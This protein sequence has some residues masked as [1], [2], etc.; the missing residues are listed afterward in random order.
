MSLG[1]M[2]GKYSSFVLC[3]F[4]SI[5]LVFS[6]PAAF[7][8]A[9]N[10]PD[11]TSSEPAEVFDTN[12]SHFPEMECTTFSVY[13]VES[14][15]FLV[16]KNIN[17]PLPPASITKVMTVLMAL[18][19]MELQDTITI[20]RAMYEGIPED[21]SKLFVVEG[22]IFT[23]ED[24]LYASLLI[25]AN[26]AAR[27]LA[28]TMA[29]SEEAFAEMMNK[30]ALELGCT[31]TNFTNS[32]GFADPEHLTTAHDMI[33]I[34]NEA[35]KNDV[36]RKISTATGYIIQPTN[37]Q[38]EQRAL[39]NSNRYISVEEL[40]YE[41]YIG[42]KTGFTDISGYTLVAGAEKDG[43]RLVGALFGSTASPRRYE[44]LR[45]AFEYCFAN[46]ELLKLDASQFEEIQGRVHSAVQDS[47]VT[48]GYP[49]AIAE[50]YLLFDDYCSLR[51]GGAENYTITADT[52]AITIRN[53]SNR[54]DLE[55][56]VYYSYSDGVRMKAGTIC[57][58][59]AE[60]HSLGKP[61]E[62][63]NF[64]F[65]KPSSEGVFTNILLIFIL[66]LIVFALICVLIRTI[67]R[68]RRN[69]RRKYPRI[70]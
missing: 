20:T 49:L 32:F 5:F 60:I 7:L 70:L 9:D 13:D 45:N 22:E 28:L 2:S 58:T 15:V 43:R 63:Q 54:Q 66:V 10:L 19:N 69:A 68:K 57:L 30:R 67:R 46:Y 31:N 64:L 24:I 38:L 25:S 52:S 23:V 4:L 14:G 33:L 51:K 11:G 62:R 12:P 16:G 40:I 3:F 18:E 6:I 29:D 48:A 42:G 56:P 1:R 26:D 59:L 21:Y 41:P 8:R 47:I 17:T 50:N 39:G 27:S 61:T 35:L 53:D 36:Y 37:K 44:D 65:G 34:L 55:V